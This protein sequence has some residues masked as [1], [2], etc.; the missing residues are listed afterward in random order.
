VTYPGYYGDVEPDRPAVVMGSAGTVVTYGQLDQRSNRLARL[1][2]DAGL[3]RGDRIAVLME[4][5]PRY[6]EVTWAALRSGLYVTPVNRHL[7]PGEV[8]Y[9]VD[10]CAASAV[11][12]SAAMSHPGAALSPETIARIP[13]R[14]AVDG[15]V[16]GFAPYEDAIEAWSPDRLDDETSGGYLFYSSGTTGRPKGVVQPLPDASPAERQPR[17]AALSE[18]YGYREGMR[19]LSPAP[20]YHAAP[21]GACVSV[22]RYGGTVVMMERFEPADALRLIERHRITHSQWVPTMFIRMLRLGDEERLGPDLSSHESATHAAAPCPV[23]VKRRMIEWWGPIVYEYYS[24]TELSGSTYITSEQWLEHPGSV[25]R[26]TSG[27]VH[28]IGDDGK[29]LRAGSV[30][31]VYFGGGNPFRYHNDPEKTAEAYLPGGLSTMGDVGYV[32]ED[33]WLYLTDRKAHTIVSGGVNIYPREAEDVLLGHPAVAD[34][35]VFGVPDEDMGERVEAAVQPAP[36][37]VPGPELERELIAFCRQHL[38]AFKCPRSVDFLD[39]LPRLPTGKL[40]KRLLRDAA[41]T[42]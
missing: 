25:G 33:G 1:L 5:N 40:A 42:Q 34:V 11:V 23:D 35:A 2:R 31:V 32:D 18:L 28:I 41:R 20:M 4:N 36:D 39:E 16:D 37:A 14:L 13:V 19:Y 3:R 6:L 10:D 26:P 38:A 21:L 29:E 17:V 27:T 9:I 30:G 22:Q 12:V 7:T 24:G 15:P 8:A